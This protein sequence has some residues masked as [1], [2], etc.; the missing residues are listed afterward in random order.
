[1]LLCCTYVPSPLALLGPT[2][3]PLPRSSSFS[4]RCH[5]H[6]FLSCVLSPPVSSRLRPPSSTLSPL[7]LSY[8]SGCSVVESDTVVGCSGVGGTSALL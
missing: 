3:L 2:D 4:F 7:P 1:M 6:G 5:F 8:V